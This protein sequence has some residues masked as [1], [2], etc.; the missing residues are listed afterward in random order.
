MRYVIGVTG[1]I[2]SGKSHVCN[3]IRDN[4]Y[5]V[6]DCDQIVKDFYQIGKPIYE[7]ILNHYGKGYLLPDGNINKDKLGKFIFNDSLQR[8]ILDNLTHPIIIEEMKRQIALQEGLVFVEIPLLFEGR[9]E[10]MFDRIICVYLSKKHQINRL[11]L[12]DGIDK[13]YAKRKI[14]SQLD[15]KYKK[16]MSHYVIDSSGDFDETKLETERVLQKIE[17][18]FLYGSSRN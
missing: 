1:G 15:L 17:G 11:M 18:E 5:N 9:L 6:I 7:A 13:Q 12:R 8:T 14:E 4:G 16:K 10:H 3:V 2:A